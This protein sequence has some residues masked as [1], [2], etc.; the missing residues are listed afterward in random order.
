MNSPEETGPAFPRQVR[1]PPPR[2]QTARVILALILREMGSTY[3]RSPGGYLWAILSPI[4]VILIF[5]AAFSFIVR[6]PALGTSFVLF[7]ATGYLAFDLVMGVTGAIT[8]AIN[9]SRP[10]LAYPR[11]TWIDSVMARFILNTLTK[12]SVFCIV[13][14][15]IQLL[16]DAHTEI[17]LIHI[18]IGL[19]MGAVL[20]LGMGLINCYLI[21]VAPVWGRIWGIVT[22]PLLIASG[23][24]FLIDELPRNVREILAWNPIAHVVAEVRRG[25][26]PSY[27]PE[28]VSYAYVCGIALALTALALLLLRRGYLTSLER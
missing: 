25:F 14:T 6:E 27:Y 8:A 12:L 24:L 4:G 9:Y 26:Y 19:S 20:G 15:G 17:S 18:V 3:G 13:M 23:V 16:V 1:L 28:Y 2:F 21:G 11:V 7:Y 5:A 22:R 10:L